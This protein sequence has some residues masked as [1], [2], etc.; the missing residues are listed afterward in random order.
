MYYLLISV[1]KPFEGK[2]RSQRHKF[3]ASLSKQQ[4]LQA[5]K[6]KIIKYTDVCT[7]TIQAHVH[8]HT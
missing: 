4:E 6:K 5:N 1:G 2:R 3:I 7:S 8:M